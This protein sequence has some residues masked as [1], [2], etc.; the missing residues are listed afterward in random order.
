MEEHTIMEV[1]NLLSRINF[2]MKREGDI[3]FEETKGITL[4]L[5]NA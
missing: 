2:I 1:L 4:R 3:R 5:I